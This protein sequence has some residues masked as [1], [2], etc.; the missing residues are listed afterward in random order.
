MAVSTQPILKL[1][2]RLSGVCLPLGHP[3]NL[4]IALYRII[5]MSHAVDEATLH[6]RYVV[7]SGQALPT[8]E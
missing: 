6:K 7:A 4:Y 3:M 8:A 1:H 2:S 5:N